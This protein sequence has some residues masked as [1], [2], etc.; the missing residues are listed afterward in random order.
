VTITFQPGDLVV[1]R[2]FQRD[3]LSRVWLGRVAADDEHGLWL[4]VATGSAY[5]DLGT[6]DGR[7][8]RLITFT[9]WPHVDKAWDETPWQGRMLM[10]H[11]REGDY[12]VWLFLDDEGALLRWYV[13]L[14]R[15]VVRW[16]DAGLGGVDTTDYDLDVIVHPDLSWRWKDEELYATRLTTPDA[17]W[18]DDPDRVAADLDPWAVSPR[19]IRQ[20]ESPSVPRAGH[21]AVFDYALAQ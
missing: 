16:R 4:W 6:A 21:N 13:N 3:L 15:P 14:E 9:D 10:L 2:H 19:A 5:R 11:P 8:L 20:S 12:S 18:V 17:Y 1:R 7:H